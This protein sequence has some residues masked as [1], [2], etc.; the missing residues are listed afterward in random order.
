M[1]LPDKSGVKFSLSLKNCQ[2]AVMKKVFQLFS[3]LGSIKV[4]EPYVRYFGQNI[5]TL[6]Y[7]RIDLKTMLTQ[8]EVGRGTYFLIKRFYSTI[9]L[10]LADLSMYLGQF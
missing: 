2:N 10:F 1:N 8:N 3:N 7:V 4:E 6:F 5:S 9:L